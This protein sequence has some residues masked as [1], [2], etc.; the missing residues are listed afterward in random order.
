[1]T[2][3][4]VVPIILVSLVGGCRGRAP[5]PRHFLR[6]SAM[7]SPPRQECLSLANVLSLGIGI[8]GEVD[9]LAEVLRCLLAVACRIG[10][11]GGSPVRA[12]A[13]GGL[14]EGGL[15]LC[16][17]SGRLPH[18]KQQVSKEFAERI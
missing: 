17:G 2:A 14:F 3:S 13:V 1:M 10:G 8:L 9:E 16:Q 12:E 11:A 6:G 4:P 7:L 15:E 5:K 18:L